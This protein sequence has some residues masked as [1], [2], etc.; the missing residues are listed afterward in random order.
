ME[1]NAWFAGKLAVMVV[2]MFGFGYLLVPMYDVFCELT[3]LNGKTASAAAIATEA[4][5]DRQVTVEFI[6]STNQHAPW[7]FRPA[8]SKMTVQPGKFYDTTFFAR[9]RTDRPLIGHAVPSV[10]PG[11]AARHFQKTEC[12]CFTEQDFDAHEG[13][14]M[15]LRFILDP[16]LP[17]HIETVTLSYTFFAQQRVADSDADMGN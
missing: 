8:V 13:R 3:G 15:P 4:V 9:N 2:A 16:D 11:Q 17:A 6:A 14:D 7:E 1:G 12:F 10:A 5:S